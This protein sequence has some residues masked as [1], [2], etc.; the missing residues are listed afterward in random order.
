M[1][2]TDT[3]AMRPLLFPGDQQFWYETLR[4]LDRE[5]ATCSPRPTE[6]DDY[7]DRYLEAAEGLTDPSQV[8]S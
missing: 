2:T 8:E 7:H 6:A 5:L 4:A 3:S 1:T